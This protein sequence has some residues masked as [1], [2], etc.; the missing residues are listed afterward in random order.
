MIDK[1]QVHTDALET[2]GML[3]DETAERDAIH[4]AVLPVVADNDLK[5]GEHIGLTKDGLAT[6]Y[7]SN[8]IGIVDPFLKDLVKKGERFWMVIYPREITSLRHVWTHPAILEQ[9][10]RETKVNESKRWLENFAKEWDV[11]YGCLVS[12]IVNENRWRG[13]EYL[14][15]FDSDIHG[16]IPEEFWHHVKIVFDI[17]VSNDR[18]IPTY[19]S[20]S[21]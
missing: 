4:L 17:D 14:T 7:A 21:C 10:N 5:P 1:R 2:L 12:S 9:Y 11:D 20:C 3:I 6:K 18:V 16:Q 8:F 15:V 19:F 13:D